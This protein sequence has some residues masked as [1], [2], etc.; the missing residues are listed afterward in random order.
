[1]NLNSGLSDMGLLG[2]LPRCDS[3]REG[4]PWT[5]ETAPNIYPD[6]PE[7]PKIS[8]VTPSFNQGNFIE[9]TI[10][11]VLLQNYPSLEYIIQDAGSTDQ[12]SEIIRKYAPWLAHCSSE[13]DKGQSDAINKGFS[14][15]RGEIINWINSDDILEPGALFAI[16]KA[17][18]ENQ[19]MDFICGKTLQFGTGKPVVLNP[20]PLQDVRANLYAFPHPQ[21]SSFYK[22]MLVKEVGMIDASL[23]YSMD[24]DLFLRLYLSGTMLDIEEPVARFRIHPESKTS[25]LE[26]T[27]LDDD[28]R[29]FSRLLNTFR[30][31]SVIQKFDDLGFYKAEEKPYATKKQISEKDLDFCLYMF[32]KTRFYG[33]QNTEEEE[34]IW[35]ML[36]LLE[37]SG[38]PQANDIHLSAISRRLRI[39]RIA[40][41]PG[42]IWKRLQNKRNN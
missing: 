1:M 31:E 20:S 11:S 8:I 4:W 23:R 9:E 39:K 2:K 38:L 29:I 17:F 5:V 25:T 10:R 21:M 37:A 36:M 16:G 15:A 19:G 30:F 28:K 18:R 42:R 3:S 7:W 40:G 41:M 27:R 13:K 22:L 32:L 34:V 26:R 35:K 12:T 14:K 24:Y 6:K 33:F